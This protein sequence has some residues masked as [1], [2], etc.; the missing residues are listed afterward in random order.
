M[1]TLSTI[2]KNASI[3]ATTVFGIFAF[4]DMALT[5]EKLLNVSRYLKSEDLTETVGR[6]PD[7]PRALMERVFGTRHF[8]WRCVRDSIL[9]SIAAFASMIVLTLLYDQ[10]WARDAR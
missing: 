8:S 6:L 3:V 4:A 7:G 1:E 9:F 5:P 10:Q 2:F